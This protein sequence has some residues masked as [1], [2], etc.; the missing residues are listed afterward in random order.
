MI[1]DK[2]YRSMLEGMESAAEQALRDDPA[3][4]DTLRS[5]KAEIDRDPRVKAAISKLHFAGS[6]IYSSLVPRIKI[7]IRTITGEISLTD[8]EKAS[9]D[10]PPGVA[11][12]TQELRNATNAVMLR[13]GYREVLDQIM[14]QAVES[15]DRFEQIAANVERAGN[16]V[17][18]CLDLS[19]YA[20]VQELTESSR[21]G[22]KAQS[23]I[24]PLSRLLSEQDRRF[25]K[26][27]KISTA[28]I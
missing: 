2:T 3:F 19:A 7:R 1:D 17:V 14:N 15:S 18:I 5:L 24:G 9:V 25:L 27:L 20:R 12:L 6:R 8:G 13:G 22:T 11:H 28:E 21:Q 4:Y 26:E 10:V 16:E 23:S